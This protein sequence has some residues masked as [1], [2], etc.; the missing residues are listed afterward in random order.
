MKIRHALLAASILGFASAAAGASE[1]SVTFNF[2]S[3]T[4]KLDLSFPPGV[5]PSP[6]PQVFVN[7]QPIGSYTPDVNFTV[8]PPSGFG[9]IVE[10][11][12]VTVSGNQT[13]NIVQFTPGPPV[14]VNQHQEFLLG[15]FHLVDGI[16][17]GG[18]DINFTMTTLSSDPT[19]NN[20]TYSDTLRMVFNPFDLDPNK[21]A[22]WFYMV[23]QRTAFNNVTCV[24]ASPTAVCATSLRVYELFDS[25]II[26]HVDGVSNA[27][28]VDLYGDIDALEL[29]EFKNAT[30][31]LFLSNSFDTDPNAAATPL[32]AALPM[33]MGG[34]GLI[35]LLVRRRKKKAAAPA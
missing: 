5:P 7:T 12:E 8:T 16:W 35:G 33:F 10:F 22:D 26:P 18:A 20:L 21:S 9:Q 17:F 11:H 24:S 14:N 6:L 29:L 1:V 25:P 13:D 15:T 30:G 27:G 31:G 28:D 3:F 34:A 32:P 4:S 19:L 2:T 23:N